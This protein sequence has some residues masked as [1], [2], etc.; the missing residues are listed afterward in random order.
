ME[1][2]I[3]YVDAAFLDSPHSIFTFARTEVQ[4]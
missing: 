3:Y 1:A 2:A 4:V